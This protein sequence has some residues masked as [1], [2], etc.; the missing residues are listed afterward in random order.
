MTD[1]EA[2]VQSLLA[3]GL[4]TVFGLPGVQNDWLYNALYDAGGRV[5]VIHT[6]DRPRPSRRDS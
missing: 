3:H 6:H 1:G 5:R 2:M 4:D